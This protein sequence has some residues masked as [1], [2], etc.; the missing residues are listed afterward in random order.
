M[1]IFKIILILLV[2]STISFGQNKNEKTKG[3]LD[4]RN[5]KSEIAK[6]V[7]KID[8]I[9]PKVIS[10]KE[11]VIP[12]EP[13]RDAKII[14]VKDESG[15]DYPKYLLPIFTL[16]LGIV[17]N[18]LL[19]K[20]TNA[21][22]IKRAGERWIVE[23][24]SLED[25]IKSQIE[26][27][28]SFKEL[29]AKEDLTPSTLSIYSAIN[30]EVFKSLDKNDLIKYIEQKN[31]K[32]WYKL[33]FF[34]KDET[35]REEYHKIVKI[36]NKTHGHISILVH[37]FELI[38]ERFER[39]LQG[40]STYTTSLTKNLQIFNRAFAMYGVELEKEGNFDMS[41]D[42]RYKP[43][44]DLFMAYIHPHLNDG[45]YNPIILEKNFFFPVVQVLSQF[46]LDDRII[47]LASAATACLN[48]I[49]GLKMEKV[50]MTENATTL[51]TR[52]NEQ[53]EDLNPLI[54]EIDGT[55]K[56]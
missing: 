30:G 21:I 48:D 14:L 49:A 55:T 24:R 32:P 28:K 8:S 16:L 46:R 39:Y 19:D 11:T 18:K 34:R 3:V 17:I 26:S 9:K 7:N 33:P 40:T 45:K 25:P 20:Y 54:N 41:T 1:R 27:L 56:L 15:T 12:I 47:P 43:L 23:L 13:K 22:K 50:Y 44:G 29:L 36:S 4:S 5:S 2:T 52:Y 31:G 38:K 51:I 6:P 53:L 35:K 42:V 10:T 37:Q